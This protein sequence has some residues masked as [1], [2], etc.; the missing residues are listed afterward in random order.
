MKQIYILFCTLIA[1]VSSQITIAGGSGSFFNLTATGTPANL[2][3]TLC[4]NGIG[5]LSCQNYTASALNLNIKKLRSPI[6]FI[7]LQ[8]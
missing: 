6:I 2:S 7:R 5:M 8:G 1:I 4:L 3:L